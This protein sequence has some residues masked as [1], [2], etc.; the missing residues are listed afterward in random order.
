MGMFDSILL[1][2]DCPRC[3]LREPV[4]LQTKL[5]RCTL[6]WLEKGNAVER[7]GIKMEDGT[8]ASFTEC[9][10]CKWWVDY[11]I[12]VRSGRI[13]YSIP[14]GMSH[15]A[16]TNNCYIKLSEVKYE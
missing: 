14:T 9:R 2:V 3:Y 8:I 4:E 6:K 13:A 7:L 11:I 12:F 16:G 5:G 10:L 15:S 1:V